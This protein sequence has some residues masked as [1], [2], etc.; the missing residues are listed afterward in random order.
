MLAPRKKS[1]NNLD[2]ILKS[3]DINLLTNVHKV[4]PMVFPVLMYG[5]ETWTIKKTES[6]ITDA[7]EVLCWRR[8][9]RVPWTTKKSSQSILKEVNPE[10]SPEGLMLKF[11]YFGYLVWRADLWKRAWCWERLRAGEEGGNRGW[12]GGWHYQHNAHE[13]WNCETVKKRKD[14]PVAVHGVTKIRARLCNWTTT[15]S[16][17]MT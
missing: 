9:L 10:N 15:K 1:Y 11:Q 16:R 3:R 12:D 14:L 5:C 7:F 8:L 13:F 2:S 6:W 4:K 17:R